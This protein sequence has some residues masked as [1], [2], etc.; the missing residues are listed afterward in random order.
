M[1]PECTRPGKMGK[2]TTKDET[3]DGGSFGGL[4]A[5]A[6][7]VGAVKGT[8]V[9]G[10]LFIDATV[11]VEFVGRRRFAN[12]HRWR[13]RR[14]RRSQRIHLIHFGFDLVDVV[15]R[16]RGGQRSGPFAHHL[17]AVLPLS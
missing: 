7:D 4:A 12:R 9:A 11:D 10:S 6:A 13:W 17:F 1:K 3:Y 16:R 5:A 15:G 14:R 8:G 2:R